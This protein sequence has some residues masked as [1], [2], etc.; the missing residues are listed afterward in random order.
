MLKV[1]S[2]NSKITRQKALNLF[3][4]NIILLAPLSNVN[5]SK[6]VIRIQKRNML[7][8]GKIFKGSHVNKTQILQQTKTNFLTNTYASVR[9]D[10]VSHAKNKHWNFQSDETHLYLTG[11]L[12]CLSYHSTTAYY[13]A[14]KNSLTT[15][16]LKDNNMITIKLKILPLHSTAVQKQA[17][18]YL[19][20]HEGISIAPNTYTM[21]ELYENRLL[22]KRSDI[23]NLCCHILSLKQSSL[24]V[25]PGN[26]PKSIF[27]HNA[28]LL[29]EKE[30]NDLCDLTTLPKARLSIITD[31]DKQ[32]LQTL[33]T[34]AEQH[35]FTAKYTD[36]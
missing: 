8:V 10:P 34:L 3:R 26:G 20:V 13:T 12:L 21:K 23:L 28:V 4:I 14:T 15:H 32:S 6:S 30:L 35:N 5:V 17:T 36:V 24:R 27:I 11:D 19:Q 29:T 18:Q 1:F 33:L 7:H 16:P 31:D 22:A 2:Y 25:L 9:F